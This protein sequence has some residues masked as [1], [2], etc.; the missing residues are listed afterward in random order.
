MR[1]ILIALG[2]LFCALPLSAAE[3]KDDRLLS[4]DELAREIDRQIE[5][6]WEHDS[7]T[8]AP[9]ADDAE[10]LRRAWL[11]LAGTIPPAADVRRFLADDSPDKR[12]RVIDELLD[13]PDHVRHSTTVWRRMLLPEADSDFQVRY[14][15]MEFEAWL[16]KQFAEQ[17]PYDEMVRRIVNVPLS[18]SGMEGAYAFYSAQ[19]EPRPT[20]FYAA[21]MVKAENLA[22]A[23][24]RAFL[25]VRIECAQCHAHPFADWSREQFWQYAAFFGG[26]ER[27][28]RRSNNLLDGLAEVFRRRGDKLELAIPDTDKVVSPVYLD[29]TTPDLEAQAPRKALA[30]WITSRD[31]PY[32]ARATV[33]RVWASLLGRGI[34][35]PVDDLVASPAS[36]PELLD[37][38]AQQFAAHGFD[39]RYLTRAIMNS[40][41]YQLS[42]RAGGGESGGGESGGGESAAGAGASAGDGELFARMRPRAMTAEQI[43][44]SLVQ[45]LGLQTE[46]TGP[47]FLETEADGFKRLFADS[48]DA[49]ERPTTVLQALALMNGELVAGATNLETGA[50]LSAVAELPLLS[51]RQ[52][53]ETLF[54]ATLSRPPRP[55]E[56]ERFAT[57]VETGGQTGDRKQALGDVLWA[58]LNC[59]E[60]AVNH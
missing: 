38:L 6:R 13:S 19:R 18:G 7:V 15:A 25:G 49:A 37:E 48:A 57:Y 26:I 8:P 27:S 55:E 33:N 4:A 43:Y 20:A 45:A 21:K 39:L 56:F 29:G 32:F 30:E 3:P 53:V 36:H 44:D 28:A 23:T 42:S 40:R 52:R 54:F 24:S 34:V 16:R 12:R 46:S 11:D 22:A 5:A 9:L 35:D 51:D 41:T 2:G 31:N 60:F 1:R 14:V 59:S 50:A 10:F 47:Y 58:L 17:T